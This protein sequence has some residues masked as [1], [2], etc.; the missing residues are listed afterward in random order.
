MENDRTAFEILVR[1]HSPMLLAFI[2]AQVKDS[3]AIED[4]H[5]ETMVTAWRILDR[6]DQT[7][8]FGPWLRGI[9]RNHILVHYRRNSR[10]PLHCEEEVIAHLDARLDEISERSGDTWPEKLEALDDCLGALPEPSRT[11]IDLHYREEMSTERIAGRTDLNRETV[12]KRLQ[13]IRAALARC[14][15]HKG[16]LAPLPTPSS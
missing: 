5:Q 12:K 7:R 3:G 15:Q 9:A 14:L 2:R 1:E 11:L 13:R 6:F 10:L 4:I 8:L 16:V